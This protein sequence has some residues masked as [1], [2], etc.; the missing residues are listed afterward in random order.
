MILGDS[1]GWDYAPP[2]YNR[3][4]VAAVPIVDPRFIGS[5]IMTTSMLRLVVRFLLP[6][7]TVGAMCVSPSLSVADVASLSVTADTTLNEAS[8]DNNLGGNGQILVGTDGA[9]RLRR[10]LLQFDVAGEIPAGSVIHSA[11]LY[12]TV[13]AANMN[14]G[15]FDLHRMFVG[16]GDGTGSGNMGSSAEPGEATWNSRFHGAT[17]WGE[18]GGLAGTDYAV[19]LSSSQFVSAAGE[20]DFAGLAADVQA[21]LDDPTSNFGWMLVSALEGTAHTARQ[22]E[23]SETVNDAPQPRLEI[24]YSAVPE[25]A[26]LSLAAVGGLL[27]GAATLRRRIIR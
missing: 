19:G 1:S 13:S 15:A 22:F 21:M 24:E 7:A 27:A 4:T 8:P 16:W 5:Y 12:I 11:T 23:S 9:G 2:Y 14:D 20:Y 18:P 10:G 3:T 25:P 26:A 6:V 17:P